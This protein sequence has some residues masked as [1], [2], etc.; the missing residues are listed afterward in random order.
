MADKSYTFVES[1]DSDNGYDRWSNFFRR[2]TRRASS[3]KD[4][5]DQVVAD[6]QP[7][8]CISKLTIIGH[9]GEGNISVGNG[10]SGTDPAKEI[11]GN[12]EAQWGPELD[13]LRCRFCSDGLVYLR[14]CNVGAGDAGANKLF[15]INGH[16]QCAI[17]QAPSG[18][19][20]PFYTTGD[21]QTSKP[22]DSGQPTTIQNPDKGK[23]KKKGSGEIMNILA[24]PSADALAEVDPADI[25]GARYLPRILGSPFSVDLLDT[26]ARPLPDSA[27]DV[28]QQG[29]ADAAPQWTPSYAFKVDGYLQLKVRGD[30]DG[31]YVAAGALL[32]HATYYSP[33]CEDT[34]LTF[35]L[36][37][38]LSQCLAQFH[39]QC[40]NPNVA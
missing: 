7:D 2:G 8:D 31:S 16:L 22:G 1:T 13:R 26:Q 36:P 23:K 30:G 14:G 11:N 29:F 39:D 33:L 27:L 38:E 21:D 24:G 40:V 19:V 37:D 20:N 6:L 32:G 5:V 25:L 3:V 10:Q 17:V 9:G 12:N 34:T 4:L 15:R 18:E 28:M 35:V